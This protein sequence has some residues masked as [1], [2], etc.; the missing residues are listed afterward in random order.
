MEKSELIKSITNDIELFKV[1][2]ESLAKDLFNKEDIKLFGEG[3]DG[4]LLTGE[5]S[6]TISIQD[7]IKF[8][9][10]DEFKRECE[11]RN[12]RNTLI[13]A[14]NKFENYTS[15]TTLINIGIQLKTIRKA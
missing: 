3:R 4:K 6:D 11:F 12:L 14:F 8:K 5:L 10:F 13:K 2:F 1:A 9:S 15:N 7:V